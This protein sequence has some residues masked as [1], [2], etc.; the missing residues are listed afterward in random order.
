MVTTIDYSTF[1]DDIAIV[2]RLIDLFINYV[3]VPG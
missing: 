3:K 2:Y 1:L